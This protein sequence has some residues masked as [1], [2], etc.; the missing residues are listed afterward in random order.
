MSYFCLPGKYIVKSG[1]D[2]RQLSKI[3]LTFK[4]EGPVDVQIEEVN[5]TSKYAED[6]GLVQELKKYDEVVQGKD[7]RKRT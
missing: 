3:M 7:E 1:T 2:F 5:V 6:E 4:A